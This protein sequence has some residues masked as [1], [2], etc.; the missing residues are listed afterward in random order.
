LAF[1]FAICLIFY[2]WSAFIGESFYE[3]DDYKLKMA[4][5]GDNL[6]VPLLA[7]PKTGLEKW[8]ISFSFLSSFGDN[9]SSVFL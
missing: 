2:F 3:S 6:S 1:S 9:E 8:V 4:F 7:L 5:L